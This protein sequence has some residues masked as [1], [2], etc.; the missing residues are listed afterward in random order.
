[1]INTQEK[2]NCALKHQP[3]TIKK[4]NYKD[5]MYHHN[6]NYDSIGNISSRRLRWIS[7]KK[8]NIALKNPQDLKGWESHLCGGKVPVKMAL[9]HRFAQLLY[10]MTTLLSFLLNV[11]KG[12]LQSHGNK[13]PRRSKSIFKGKK[14]STWPS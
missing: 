4:S 10:T 2:V 13:D 14:E 9:F 12:L 1:M 11:T 5:L 7:W 8:G 3:E 6:K